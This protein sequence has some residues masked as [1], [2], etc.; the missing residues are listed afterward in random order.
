MLYHFWMRSFSGRVPVCAATSFFRSPMVSSSL[1]LTRI[2]FPCGRRRGARDERV[3]DAG[4]RGAREGYRGT[5]AVAR[6]REAHQAVVE[7]DL[8]HLERR[9]RER[10]ARRGRD[11][12]CGAPWS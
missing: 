10:A 6:G 8:D 1:H 3:R 5:A 9:M 12:M 2:F 11:G 4:T 7:D